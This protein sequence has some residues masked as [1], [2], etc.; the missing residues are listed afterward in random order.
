[1]ILHHISLAFD[2]NLFIY[3][4]NTDC[5]LPRFK[6]ASKQN[7]KNAEKGHKCVLVRLCHCIVPSSVFSILI[8]VRDKT[9]RVRKRLEFLSL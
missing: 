7:I 3:F 1:M 4:D 6:A 2:S 5:I 8:V 9:W